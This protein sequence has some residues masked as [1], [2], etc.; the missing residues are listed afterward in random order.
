MD[1]KIDIHNKQICQECVGEPFLKSQID[2]KAQINTCSYCSQNA[3][4]I[5]ISDLSQKVKSAF[6]RH[7]KNNSRIWNWL[8]GN[9]KDGKSVL[10]AIRDSALVPI[11]AAKDIQTILIFYKKQGAVIRFFSF[12]SSFLDFDFSQES[13]CVPQTFNDNEWRKKWKS[14]ESTLK[15]EARYFNS[16]GARL[17]SSIFDDLNTLSTAEN[18]SLIVHAGPQQKTKELFRARVFQSNE[19]ISE[20]LKSIDI[21]LAPPPSSLA[22]GGRMNAKGISVFYGASEPEVALAEV[23]PPVGSQVLI[24]RFELIKDIKLLDLTAFSKIST[25]GSIFDEKYA[26]YIQKAM[27]L[28]YLGQRIAQPVMPDDEGIEYLV[29]QAIA[30]FLSSESKL[31]V[32]G[33]IFPSVQVGRD[34]KNFVLFHRSS[35]VKS[36]VEN[37]SKKLKIN[38]GIISEMGLPSK[39]EIVQSTVKASDMS[40]KA[41]VHIEEESRIL[42]SKYLPTLKLDLDSIVVRVV[43]SV[44]YTTTENKVVRIEQQQ[45]DTIRVL[46]KIDERKN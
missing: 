15:T 35:F 28:K 22:S 39:Y 44:K 6:K 4:C 29:T 43:Q 18:S 34:A 33:V 3:K 20:A 7:Y 42:T 38:F 9:N 1:T 5:I 46:S 37:S 40:D 11:E 16:E 31:K 2:T 8:D 14:F 36:N 41:I 13:K 27:F 25:K 17:L 45:E 30:D 19:K 23:R 12:F 32:D 26:S 24:G 10:E 21:N